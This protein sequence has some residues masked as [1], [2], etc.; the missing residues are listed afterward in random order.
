MPTRQPVIVA[1]DIYYDTWCPSCQ[2]AARIRIMLHIRDLGHPPVADLAIC[3]ACGEGYMPTRPVV[4]VDP[5]KRRW[6]WRH[7]WLRLLWWL[8]R[9]RCIKTGR[10]P[11]ACGFGDC[12]K[13]GW[14]DC[15]WIEQVDFGR[16]RHVFCGGSH[17]AQWLGQHLQIPPTR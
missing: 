4:T 8:Q 5:L 1:G 3:T 9:R 12:P 11:T 2:T 16:V 10:P 13:P 6:P 14:W 15:A 7:P 17:R